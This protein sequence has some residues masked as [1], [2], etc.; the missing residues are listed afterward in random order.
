MSGLLRLWI[1]FE[2]DKTG[3]LYAEFKAYGFSGR[4]SAWFQIPL[5]VEEARKFAQYPLEPGQNP[6]INGGYWNS[7]ATEIAE[8]HLHLSAHQT[9][10]RG[11]VALLV[12]LAVNRDDSVRP[13]LLCSAS[14]EL[15]A[16]Y[17][18]LAK[19]SRDLESL[20][21]GNATEVI[22]STIQS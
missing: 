19:F 15:V 2:D 10:S 9:N 8:E 1:N 6:C 21:C 17:E 12:K 16:S 4:S 20:A 22:F 3:E 11:G 13:G 7:D 5:L 14:A 18:Q